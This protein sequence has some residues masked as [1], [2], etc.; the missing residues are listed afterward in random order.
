MTTADVKCCGNCE[1][2]MRDRFDKFQGACAVIDDECIAYAMYH[3]VTADCDCPAWEPR[4]VQEH[5]VRLL[6]GQ[7]VMEVD[8]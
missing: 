3:W 6:D 2:F 1:A 5:E 8:A 4:K 7:M